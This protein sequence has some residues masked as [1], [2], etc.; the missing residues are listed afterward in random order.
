MGVERVDYYSE[1]EYRQAKQAELREERELILGEYK[2]IKKE[3]DE[4]QERLEMMSRM[5]GDTYND[6]LEF[7]E[8]RD[9]LLEASKE[10]ILTI[11][12]VAKPDITNNQIKIFKET[13]KKIKGDDE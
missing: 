3:R 9:E 8:Q 13:V 1:E 11:D 10:L 4:I 7:K 2:K 12:Y 6:A 5:Y